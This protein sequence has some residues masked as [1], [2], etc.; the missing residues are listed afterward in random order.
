MGHHDAE[1]VAA[2]L[3]TKQLRPKSFEKNKHFSQLYL[4]FGVMLTSCP[5]PM[6]S[7]I[8]AVAFKD[9][10]MFTPETYNLYNLS[11]SILSMPGIVALLFIYLF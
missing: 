1:N 4:C 5:M 7:L 6:L 11:V 3:D 9:F 8:G 2:A 10:C